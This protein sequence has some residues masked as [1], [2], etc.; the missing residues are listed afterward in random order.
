MKLKQLESMLQG[1]EVFHTPKIE[2]EQYPTSAHI[3]SRMLYTAAN[4]YG[5]VAGRMCV[6]LGCGTGMLGI[7]A[8]ALDAG[9]VMGIDIDQDALDLA[10]KNID[11][12]F[13]DDDDDVVPSIDLVNVDVRAIAGGDMPCMDKCADTVVTNPPFGTRCK[14]ADLVFLEAAFRLSRHAVY[15]LHKTSTRNHIGKVVQNLLPCCDMTC[16]NHMHFIPALPK[17]SKWTSGGLSY[18]IQ[19]VMGLSI[20]IWDI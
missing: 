4:V 2:L 18:D 16:P 20:P 19:T 17:I 10:R 14:G 6:D 8:V 11:E 12:Y 7:G 3:A 9:H 5:D 13:Y 15:S 1:V